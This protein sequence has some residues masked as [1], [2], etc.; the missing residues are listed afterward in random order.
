VKT[1]TRSSFV[2]FARLPKSRLIK[3][4]MSGRPWERIKSLGSEYRQRVRLLALVEGGR[5]EEAAFHDRFYEY[6]FRGELFR[7]GPRLVEF[8]NNL[9][10]PDSLAVNSGWP[11]GLEKFWMDGLLIIGLRWN[12]RSVLRRSGQGGA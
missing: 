8:V 3:I 4:G 2:Y 11:C 10:F 7:P 9:G 5:D 1:A 12:D 6:R